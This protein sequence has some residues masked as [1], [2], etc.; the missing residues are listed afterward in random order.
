MSKLNA[1]VGTV[2]PALPGA[3]VGLLLGVALALALAYY[4]MPI[5]ATR[6]ERVFADL[7]G[8]GRADLIVWADVVFDSIGALAESEFSAFGPALVPA[9]TTE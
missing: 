6:V 9:A 8:D 7:N 2:R 4:T 1:I 3:V 5:S